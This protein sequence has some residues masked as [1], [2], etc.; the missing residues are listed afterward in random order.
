[1]TTIHLF[2]S[3]LT[4]SVIALAITGALFFVYQGRLRRLPESTR[5]ED[6]RERLEGVRAQL[7]AFEKERQALRDQLHDLELALPGASP[8][9]RRNS[10]DFSMRIATRRQK[11]RRRCIVPRPHA[12]N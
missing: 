2:Y 3:G 7:E 6:L 4:L 10:S 1:M 8:P 11:S 9:K 5:Y 12:S